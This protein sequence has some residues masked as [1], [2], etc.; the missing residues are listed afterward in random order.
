MIMINV[1]TPQ[2]HDAG[3]SSTATLGVEAVFEALLA[4]HDLLDEDF[5]KALARY[6]L[7]LNYRQST[8]DR[9]AHTEDN[10]K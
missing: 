9:L 1:P 3:S 2:K 7:E 6:R 10:A 8:W 4:D 5:R